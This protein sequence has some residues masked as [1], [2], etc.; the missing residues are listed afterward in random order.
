MMD[1]EVNSYLVFR[2]DS[3][4]FAAHVGKV[5]EIL[6]YKQPI[7]MPN[8]PSFLLGVIEHRDEMV[9][10][11]DPSRKFG[12]NALSLTTA[13]CIIVLELIHSSSKRGVKIGVVV[14][15]VTD[16]IEP[17]GDELKSIQ[18]DFRPDYI[19]GTYKREGKFYLVLNVDKVFSTNE[20]IEI[21]AIIAD[22][23][24]E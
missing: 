9:P 11:V 13:S 4:E 18:N 21:S 8:S 10:V 23:K 17:D 3:N 1:N 16:I 12:L 2:I 19:L 15:A 20:I 24:K 14:D 6:E 22:A 5:V 7:S